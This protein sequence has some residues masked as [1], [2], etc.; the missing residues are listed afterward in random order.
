MIVK[1]LIKEL[2]KCLEVTKRYNKLKHL[3]SKN[4]ETK[5]IAEFRKIINKIK[6]K[7][8][9]STIKEIKHP[10]GKAIRED[11]R[12]G[13]F[14]SIRPC[15]KEYKDKTFLGIYIGDAA[16]SSSIAIE[17][18]AIVCR[19]SFYNPAILIPEIGKVIYGAESWWGLI[20]SED[21]LKKITDLDIENIW[22]VKA[23]KKLNDAA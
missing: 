9:A 1:E 2:D 10:E 6:F 15:G 3:F 4:D 21:D 18:D 13:S 22:Y 7:V 14:V 12:S 5:A 16:L 11:S 23:L 20:E 8:K 19:W 17:E